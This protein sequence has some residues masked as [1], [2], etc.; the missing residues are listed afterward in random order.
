MRQFLIKELVSDA[1]NWTG[2]RP[3]SLGLKPACAM[4]VWVPTAE[5]RQLASDVAQGNG[6]CSGRFPPQSCL[7]SEASAGHGSGAPNAA[8][9]VTVG[10]QWT[11]GG[12][13]FTAGWLRSQGA[14]SSDLLSP[15]WS[16]TLGSG[17]CPAE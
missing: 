9:A 13:A 11:G 7:L 2:A 12:G 6:L 16:S 8:P 10:Q 17:Y 4:Q 15:Q 5:Y 3:L 1:L 14:T